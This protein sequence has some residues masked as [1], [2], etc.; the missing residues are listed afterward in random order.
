[1]VSLPLRDRL[2]RIQSQ[3]LNGFVRKWNGD[4]G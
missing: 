2:S 3:K 4:A 1:M